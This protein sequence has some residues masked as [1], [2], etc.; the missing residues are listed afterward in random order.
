MGKRILLLGAGGY[1][2]VVLDT[3]HDLEENGKIE[4]YEIIDFMDDSSSKVVGKI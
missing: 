2:K 1:S 4:A 3:I